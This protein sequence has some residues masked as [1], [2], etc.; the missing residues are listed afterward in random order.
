MSCCNPS[1]IL[2]HPYICPNQECSVVKKV[3]ERQ[4]DFM[5]KSRT[6]FISEIK[7]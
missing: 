7:F 4:T 6:T 1:T 2:L 5:D 3:E